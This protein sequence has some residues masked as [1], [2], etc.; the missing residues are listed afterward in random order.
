MPMLVEL[1]LQACRRDVTAPTYGNDNHDEDGVQSSRRPVLR[2]EDVRS[3]AA[4]AE[5][6]GLGT[7]R[8]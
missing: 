8:K 5:P 2:T 7:T 3:T 6:S 1:V 4:A